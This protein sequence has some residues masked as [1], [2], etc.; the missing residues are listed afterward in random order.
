PPNIAIIFF[1]LGIIERDGLFLI[2]GSA[3]SLFAV[4]I[5]YILVRIAMNSLMLVL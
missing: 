5:G 4:W 3:I 2:V 1:A